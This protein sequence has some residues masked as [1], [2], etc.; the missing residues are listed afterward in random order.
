MI[1]MWFSCFEAILMIYDVC[2]SQAAQSGELSVR[3]V[4]VTH[5]KKP[6]IKMTRNLFC[7]Q[8]HYSGKEK[9]C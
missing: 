3:T 7:I 4:I 6:Q 8:L 9:I 2:I 5:K 1:Y